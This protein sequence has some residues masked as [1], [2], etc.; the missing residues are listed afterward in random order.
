MKN[1]PEFRVEIKLRNNRI[2][3]ARE[4]LGYKS[5]NEAAEK[6]GL[7]YGVFVR[8]ESF[9]LSPL[10]VDGVTWKESAIKVADALY[11]DPDDLWPEDSRKVAKSRLSFEATSEQMRDLTGSPESNLL[12]EYDKA[13]LYKLL[14]QIPKRTR[15]LLIE[16]IDGD[17]NFVELGNEHKL[18][19]TRVWQL[20]NR[21]LNN[22]RTEF[23][24]FNEEIITKET[25]KVQQLSTSKKLNKAA[26]EICGLSDGHSLQSVHF[27]GEGN[28]I[29]AC[30]QHREILDYHNHIKKSNG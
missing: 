25:K 23:G 20:I 18:S 4:L 6:L 21:E 26:C 28:R 14:D 27:S 24:I 1:H 5:A 30:H 8:Y 11:M 16:H 12:L 7:S 19:R 15:E 9:K 29:Y 13:E 22:L 17:K 10:Q 2:I 3:K